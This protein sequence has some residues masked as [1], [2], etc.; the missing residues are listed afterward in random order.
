MY[1]RLTGTEDGLVGYWPLD[2]TFEDG[3]DTKTK[4]LSPNANHGT[5]EGS[6]SL[7]DLIPVFSGADRPELAKIGD[8]Q[9]ICVERESEN[10]KTNGSFS[11]T[12]GDT[13]P[14]GWN[15]GIISTGCS[16][17]I[18]KSLY[19][20]GET[21]VKF[22]VT[23]EG[24]ALISQDQAL[25]SGVYVLSL[26]V[27][28]IVGSP[29]RNFWLHSSGNSI[30]ISNFV[31]YSANGP[32]PMK[33]WYVFTFNEDD[34]HTF[35]FGIGSNST[36]GITES[37]FIVSSLKVEKLSYPTL[38]HEG[39]RLAPS[40]VIPD[41]IPATGYIAGWVDMVKDNGHLFGGDV[42]LYVDDDKFKGEIYGKTFE[43]NIPFTWDDYEREKLGFL[44]SW[45]DT[46]LYLDIVHG[47]TITRETEAKTIT[48]TLDRDLFVGCDDTE[49]NHTSVYFHQLVKGTKET[50]T[51]TEA[52]Q[53]LADLS[54]G[55]TD[56]KLGDL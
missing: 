48:P 36:V 56:L 42:E 15:A 24:R 1:K 10:V 39:I 29:I 40:L 31:N 45:S 5:L 7:V 12:V 21:A 25:A 35:R 54:T 52:K 23:D 16:V 44:L 37:S 19:Y 28:D 3:T 14:T 2:N 4:D 49:T 22:S 30:S 17:E 43:F 47:T 27:E 6:P 34:S 18:I 20:D 51:N 11:G 32:F 13:A 33:I 8:N 41:F 50:F 55:F 9:M 38:F 46:N 26:V 53:L